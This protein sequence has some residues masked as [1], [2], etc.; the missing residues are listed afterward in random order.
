MK[1]YQIALIGPNDANASQQLLDCAREL[2]EALVKAGYR[3]VCG[4]MGGV[5]EAACKG[6]RESPH[7]FEGA[8]IGILPGTD[9]S[10]GNPYLDIVIN[11]GVGFARN[12][13]VVS[14]G[15][16]VIA[17]GGGAGTL[18]EMAF[19]WQFQKPII[20]IDLDEGWSSR[21]AGLK[22]D[23]RRDDHI[24]QTASVDYAM[25]LLA[26]LNR[27]ISFSDFPRSHLIGDRWI[28]KEPL[29]ERKFNRE[30]YRCKE[31]DGGRTGVVKIHRFVSDSDFENLRN[32]IKVM[33]TLGHDNGIPVYDH[34]DGVDSEGIV[35][36]Y[37]VTPE[38]DTDLGQVDPLTVDIDVWINLLDGL[39]SLVGNLHDEGHVHRDIKPANIL[40]DEER[41]KL[42][43]VDF[44]SVF[45][46]DNDADL[47]ESI[48]R[49]DI[50]NLGKLLYYLF[51]GKYKMKPEWLC[52]LK[53]VRSSEHW[54]LDKLRNVILKAVDPN[55]KIRF[56][57]TIELSKAIEDTRLGGTR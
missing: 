22:L 12:L 11:S 37:I 21:L 18:S 24:T 40:L 26:Q 10:E 8:T 57:S 28:I 20:A 35:Y 29:R 1:R 33:T 32:E 45:T 43:L 3:I 48:Q 52:D 41:T 25:E 19:A 54:D 42:V 36:G 53:Q 17:L 7:H 23:E 27:Q 15:D 38:F 50:Y 31:S 47:I 46:P 13:A 9:G 5:M 30:L 49:E 16:V 44:Y 4:G 34:G 2:G 6:A 14:S 39:L 51:S 56:K 55:W